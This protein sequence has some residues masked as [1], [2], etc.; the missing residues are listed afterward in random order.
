VVSYTGKRGGEKNDFSELVRGEGK[1]SLETVKGVVPL[2]RPRS[3]RV[4]L[5]GHHHEKACREMKCKK[6][7]KNCKQ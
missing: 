4:L 1:E 6:A 2:L 5:K 7:C 3:L